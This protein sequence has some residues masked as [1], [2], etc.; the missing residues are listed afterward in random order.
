M[1]PYIFNTND[2]LKTFEIQVGGGLPVFSGGR[3][4]GGGLGGTLGRFAKFAIPILQKYIFPHIRDMA[5]NTTQD[6]VT[7]RRSPKEA[8]K[9]NGINALENFG[10]QVIPILGTQ[11]GNGIRESKQKRRNNKSIPIVHQSLTNLTRIHQ[12]TNSKKKSKKS[13]KLKQK[14][15]KIDIFS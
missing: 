12:K 6:I 8:L 10:K 7:N 11:K 4:R 13:K 2:Y 1:K 3:Q 15:S 5:F 14:R 9:F